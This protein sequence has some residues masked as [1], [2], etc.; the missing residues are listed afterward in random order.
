MRL[1]MFWFLPLV[2][3]CV[4]A[5]AD[6]DIGAPQDGV[7][8]DGP[9]PVA[10]EVRLG[11]SEYAAALG[12]L[13]SIAEALEIVVKKREAMYALLGD[14]ADAKRLREAI[15]AAAEA[16]PAALEVEAPPAAARPRWNPSA[17]DVLYVQ[18]VPERVVVR[19]GSGRSLDLAK[20][21][22]VTAGVDRVELESVVT[23]TGGKAT[24][25]VLVVNGR[26]R[27]LGVRNYKD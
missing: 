7:A 1:R 10:G 11:L 12:E 23:N 8:A 17:E 20:G 6:E 13:V 3:A 5:S 4:G 21:E 27:E 26:L 9:A 2:A 19:H 16:R 18:G 14:S 25:V 22:M 24:G 15:E